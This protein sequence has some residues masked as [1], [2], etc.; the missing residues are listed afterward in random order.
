[1]PY[2]AV[3]NF[4]IENRISATEHSSIPIIS[5]MAAISVMVVAHT[6]VR[7]ATSKAMRMGMILIMLIVIVGIA[8]YKMGRLMADNVSI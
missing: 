5:R 3:T 6:P 4:L 7:K 2:L 8:K 1:L